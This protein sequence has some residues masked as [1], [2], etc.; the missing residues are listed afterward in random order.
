MSQYNSLKIQ[1]WTK[2]Q[3]RGGFT[4]NDWIL[5]STI[6]SYFQATSV[7]TSILWRHSHVKF[8][9]GSIETTKCGAGI[10]FDAPLFPNH[11]WHLCCHE[12]TGC[13][14]PNW[15]CPPVWETLGTPVCMMPEQWT[16]LLCSVSVI[17]PNRLSLQKVSQMIGIN[18]L[19]SEFL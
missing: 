6:V 15:L 18:L 8:W 13:G 1:S 19:T 14:R 16:W 3:S 17:A 9:S 7:L 4:R 11:F 12:R 2:F 5:N 10:T